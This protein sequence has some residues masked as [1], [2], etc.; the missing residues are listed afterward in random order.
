MTLTFFNRL[1]K[2]L[3]LTLLPASAMAQSLQLPPSSRE[4]FS[5]FDSLYRVDS[6]LVSGDF[7]QDLSPRSTI[8]H[9]FYGDPGWQKGSVTI[10]NILFDSLLLKYDICLNELVCH[11]A[12][13]MG[14][15]IPVSLNKEKISRFTLG[16]NEF[17]PFPAID[18]SRGIRFCEVLAKGPV[19]LLLLQSKRYRVP[20]SGSAGFIY[21]ASSRLYLLRGKELIPYKGRRTLIHL[22]P[23]LK[24]PMQ[25]FIRS[26]KLR[27]G[28][29][30]PADHAR[31]VGFCNTLLKS[32]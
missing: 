2:I 9:P 1:T 14:S 28:A 21:E 12:N 6:R 25:D 24:G 8:G 10:D 16:G 23:D 18:S 17:I 5:H 22:Y 20:A 32:S 19:S 27:P 29:K 7:Y 11:T 13:L 4:L 31:L 3:I 15:N 26:E 30:H